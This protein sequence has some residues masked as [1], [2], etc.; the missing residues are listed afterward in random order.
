[1]SII[2]FEEPPRL[3][4]CKKAFTYNSISYKQGDQITMP[5]TDFEKYQDFVEFV[6]GFDV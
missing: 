3:V 2:R 5:M 1:M 4:Q 6:S